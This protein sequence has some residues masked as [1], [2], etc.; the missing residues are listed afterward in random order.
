LVLSIAP[1]L[2]SAG[3]RLFDGS[4]AAVELEQVDSV[5]SPWATHPR[6]QVKARSRVAHVAAP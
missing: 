5:Q 4:P 2:L 6:Y 3:K 1:V